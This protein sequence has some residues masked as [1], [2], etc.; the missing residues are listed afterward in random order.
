MAPSKS[1]LPLLAA[2][3]LAS[4]WGSLGH[5]AIAYMAQGLVSSKTAQFAQELL[6]DTSS[7]YLA[8]VATWADSYRYTKEGEYSAVYHYLD[9][10]KSRP[11]K[12]HAR[13]Y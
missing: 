10:R 7:A 1:I 3:P 11:H 9:A 4:A 6:N 12:Q 13:T 8:N 2:A 5:T